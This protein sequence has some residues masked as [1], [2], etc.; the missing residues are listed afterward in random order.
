METVKTARFGIEFALLILLPA[1]VM[2]AG[3]VTASLAYRGG[4]T[5]LPEPSGII[6]NPR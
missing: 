4:F 6:V 2:V 1:A 3:A 5:P